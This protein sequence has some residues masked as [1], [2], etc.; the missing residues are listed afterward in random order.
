VNLLVLSCM[1]Y[2]LPCNRIV[3]FGFELGRGSQCRAV[4]ACSMR[5]KTP[6]FS[7][8]DSARAVV[9]RDAAT[10]LPWGCIRCVGDATNC[11]AIEAKATTLAWSC[12]DVRASELQTPPIVGAGSH[13]A[14]SQ[15]AGV[16]ELA[17]KGRARQNLWSTLSKTPRSL[18][19]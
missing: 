19:S 7:R 12:E 11:S 14:R 18:P 16:R 4:G 13:A 15:A 3:L 5:T 17:Q 8:S 1:Q 10:A 2:L 6:G 9:G